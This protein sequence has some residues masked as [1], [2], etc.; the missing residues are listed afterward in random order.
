MVQANHI[1]T[2]RDGILKGIPPEAGVTRIDFEGPEIAVY[3][4]N[5]AV[6]LSSGDVVKSIAKNLKKRIV[7]RPDPEV[8]KDKD[9]AKK[10]VYE[11]VPPE[12][13][14]TNVYFDEVMGEMVIEAKKPGMVIGKNGQVL[15]QLLAHTLWRP[16]PVRTPPLRSKFM[17]SVSALTYKNSSYR[18]RMLKEVGKRIHRSIIYKVDNVRITAL[19][20]FKEVGRSAILLEVGE[21]KILLDCGVKPGAKSYMNEF[22]SF[23]LDEFN[24]DSL[25]AIV[26]THAHLDHCG[27]LPLL[28]KYGYRGPVYCSEPTKMLMAL[29]L[30]DYLDVAN[31]EGRVP[32]YGIRD[33]KAALLHTMTLSN[34][35][36]TDIAPSVKLTLH[37]AGHILGS[38]IAHLHIGE[39]LHNI[40]YTSDFK[41]GKTR[42]LEPA[43]HVFPRL[44]TLIMESTYGGPN[45]VM[46]PREETE[47]NLIEI[48]NRTLGRGGKV[49]IPVLAV[50]RAQEI[51]LVLADAVEK[52]LIP[53]VPIYIEGMVQESTAIHTAYPENL[54]REVRDKI[55]Y[56]DVNPFLAENFVTLEK[57]HERL[58]IVEG[59][60]CII[61]TTSGM[62]N[63]GPA[64]EYF[65]L[66]AEDKR[67]SLIFVAYQVEGTLGRAIQEGAKEVVIDYVDGKPQT[68]KVEMEVHTCNGFSGHSDRKQ[69]LRF[70]ERVTPKPHRVILCHGES[71]KTMSLASSIERQYRIPVETP[72]YLDSIKIR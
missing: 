54:A 40:V 71:E 60:P 19:G 67:N 3:V 44:E 8:R 14:I 55:L 11:L 13:G 46:P 20:G 30:K 45:D 72:D 70:I 4:K 33:V 47:L 25:S 7:L 9:E 48:I 15:K 56:E 34:G 18:L 49:L 24:M 32:I 39:G 52:K 51:M 42:L 65:K 6:L 68:V 69:L 16:V 43:S 23:W 38:S 17:E 10:I 53:S 57:G 50:G 62:L 36:V 31:K 35:E 66:M 27:A 58:D 61:L 22:P 1:A 2:L 28:F 63:A 21:D 59:E 37:N 12:A 26:I 29:I 5:P 41:Y 64:L